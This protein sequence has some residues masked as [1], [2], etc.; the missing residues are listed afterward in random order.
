MLAALAETIATLLIKDR[1]PRTSERYPLEIRR[2]DG[3]V[4]VLGRIGPNGWEP[5]S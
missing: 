5:I 4:T 2:P 1:T 3:T